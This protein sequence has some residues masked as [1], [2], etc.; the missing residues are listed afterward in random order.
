M[1]LIIFMFVFLLYVQERLTGKLD[2]GQTKMLIII[3]GYDDKVFSPNLFI[4]YKYYMM[5]HLQLP[6]ES[7]VN[8]FF[9]TVTVTIS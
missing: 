3:H 6:Q 9:S 7:H 2:S 5:L 8:N 1:I 4:N